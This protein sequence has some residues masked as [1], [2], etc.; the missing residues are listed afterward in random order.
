MLRKI[1]PSLS[2]WLTPA[3]RYDCGW[4]LAYTIRP[5]PDVISG[6]QRHDGRVLTGDHLPCVGNWVNS[7]QLRPMAIEPR[8]VRRM[9]AEAWSM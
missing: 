4:G 9:I 5:T 1:A 6:R 2:R 3:A 7:A 8:S